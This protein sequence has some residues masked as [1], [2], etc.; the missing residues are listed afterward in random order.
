MSSPTMPSVQEGKKELETLQVSEFFLFLSFLSSSLFR[1]FCKRESSYSFAAAPR[2]LAGDLFILRTARCGRP[3]FS[4][5]MRASAGDDFN[6]RAGVNR[7][8]IYVRVDFV[9]EIWGFQH[10]LEGYTDSLCASEFP[11]ETLLFILS[12]RFV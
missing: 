2:R 11:R 1:S 7:V 8:Y 4:S 6:E 9:E 12:L 10:E 5:S 3:L